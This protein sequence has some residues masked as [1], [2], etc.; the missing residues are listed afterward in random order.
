MP[1]CPECRYEFVEGIKK[2]PDCGAKLVEQLSPETEISISWVKLATLSS[3]LEAEMLKEA[4]A[5]QG[6]QA[7]IQTDMFHSAFIT[8]TTTTAGSFAKV[9]VPA[10][11]ETKAR[12]IYREISGTT[13]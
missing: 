11:Q 2:C 5:N 7:I 8:Q 1:Y 10:N 3:P 4:L 12:E 13:E 9:F 6:I